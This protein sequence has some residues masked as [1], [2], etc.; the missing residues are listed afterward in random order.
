MLRSFETN[1]TGLKGV[2]EDIGA[3]PSVVFISADRPKNRRCRQ[4]VDPWFA[5]KNQ[6]E[7]VAQRC[8][9]GSKGSIN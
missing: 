5:V 7:D 2:S 8:G 9:E 6:F 3:N 4:A 1:G